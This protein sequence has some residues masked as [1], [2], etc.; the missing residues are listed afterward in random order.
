MI[1]VVVVVVALKVQITKETSSPYYGVVRVSN[2]ELVLLLQNRTA[3]PTASIERE[4]NAVNRNAS[5]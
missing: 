3:R 2:T 1:V 5:S 4:L